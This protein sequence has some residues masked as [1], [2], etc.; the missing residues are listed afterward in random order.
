MRDGRR[1]VGHPEPHHNFVAH[2]WAHWPVI[3]FHDQ[4]VDPVGK[5]GQERVPETISEWARLAFIDYQSLQARA[6]GAFWDPADGRVGGVR[7]V[8]D[9]GRD[10]CGN[11]LTG[12]ALLT[13]IG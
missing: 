7:I 5:V 10:A 4:S 2:G 1:A 9:Q 8:N 12:F 6:Q 3:S 11:F 13:H